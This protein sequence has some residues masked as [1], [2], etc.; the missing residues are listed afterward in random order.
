MSSI[1]K[2]Q[3]LADVHARAMIEFDQIQSASYEVRMQCLQDRRFYSI[4]GAQWE[5]DVGVQFENKPRFEFNKIHLALIRIFNEYRNNRIT[6]DFTSKDGAADDKLADTCDGLYRADEQDSGAQEA[7]DNCFDEGTGGGFGALRLSARYVDE[8]D[9][10]S[11]HQRVAIEPIFDADSCVYFSLDGKRQDKSDSKRCYVLSGMTPDGYR[12]EYDD[13]PASWPKSVQQTEFDWCTPDVVYVCEMYEIEQKSELV[14]TFRGIAL[15]DSEPNEIRVTAAELAEPGK[16]EMLAATGFREVRQKRV[17]RS[18]VHKYILNGNRVIEDCGHIAGTCIPIIPFYGKRWYVDGVER[19]M[20]HVRLAR[21]AQMLQNMLMSWLAEMA[22]RFDIE[23]PILTPEQVAGHA[24]MWAAD[25]VEKFPYLLINP[26]TDAQGQMV[27]SGPIGYTK[28]PNINPAMAAL[29]QIATQALDD[30]LGNQQAGE[31]LQPNLSGKAVELIQTRLDMQVFIYMSNFAKTIKRVGEVWLSMNRDLLVEPG[32]KMKVLNSNNETGTIELM[33]PLIDKETG[34]T[35]HEND[36]SQATFDVYADVGPSSSSKRAATV[37]GLTAL[38]QNVQDPE[39]R[40]VLE[41]MVVLNS[42][43]EGLAD[44]QTFF[45][46]KL[47]RMGAVMPTDE[48]KAEIAQEQANQQPDPNAEFLQ[49]SAMKAEAEAMLDKVKALLTMAQVGE[50]H[51][52]TIETLASVEQGRE[53]HA[54]GLAQQIAA[55]AVAA[56][57]AAPAPQ[58]APVSGSA[59]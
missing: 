38:L 56:P 20:G 21:D 1:P 10:E 44:V 22:A 34:E 57:A 43:G 15:N 52:K 5:G 40:T 27:A 29:L 14:H 25:N 45:R 53:Q 59:Q 47:V 19:A 30:M 13:D 16:A 17:K 37:R 9:D 54:I 39:T 49:A 24:H 4:P 35:Y 33:R 32:R 58:P 26:I 31:Q 42:E 55:P 18:R 50:S 8:D 12:E 23:K 2:E 36:L 41:S 6:V 3:R 28:A 7:Y 51:A 11:D 46:R 48:E